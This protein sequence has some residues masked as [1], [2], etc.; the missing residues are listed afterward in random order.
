MAHWYEVAPLLEKVLKH[1]LELLRLIVSDNLGVRDVVPFTLLRLNQDARCAAFITHWVRR[2]CANGSDEVSIDALHEQSAEGDWL[3][4]SADCY[5]DVLETVPD[6]DPGDVSI[7]M[8]IALCIIKLRIIAKYEVDRRQM[9]AFEATS[10]ARQLNDDSTQRITH[11]VMGAER[12]AERVAAQERLVERYLDI[13]HER[14]PTM[15]PSIINPGP[16][17][18]CDAPP[19]YTPGKPSEAYYVLRGCNRLF[20]RVPGA[21][22]RLKRRFG[23]QPQYDCEM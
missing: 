5:D 18:S 17:K 15:L 22:E 16:L 21:E 19:Y 10:A 8:L 2:M 20:V 23:S 13:V 14:N 12:Q 9:D 7:A 1:R 6:A 11:S 4:G 3:Y